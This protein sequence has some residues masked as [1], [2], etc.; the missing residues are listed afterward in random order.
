MHVGV[1]GSLLVDVH[2]PAGVV[3]EPVMTERLPRTTGRRDLREDLSGSPDFFRPSGIAETLRMGV[4]TVVEEEVGVSMLEGRLSRRREAGFVGTGLCIVTLE[5]GADARGVSSCD[6]GTR[7]GQDTLEGVEDEEV[8]FD[9]AA[10]KT[11]GVGVDCSGGLT[12]NVFFCST[13]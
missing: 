13:C 4:C 10:L 1:E 2:R 5:E 3:A 6:W 11:A 7:R 9:L 12:S 8:V